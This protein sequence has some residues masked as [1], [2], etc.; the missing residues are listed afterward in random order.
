MSKHCLAYTLISLCLSIQCVGAAELADF[1]SDGCSQ[2][3]DGTFAQ[4][5]LWCD[6][7]ITHDIAYW[8]GGSR[9]QK[10]QADAALR[11]CVLQKTDNSLLADT[12]YYGVTLGGSPVF[13][14][15]YRWGYGWRYGRGFQSLNQYEQQQVT[16]KLQQYVVSM[17]YSSCDFD[18]PV[19]VFIE[20][21]VRSL[22]K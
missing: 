18:Y 20:Q 19:K 5:D 16:D 21:E 22:L 6:C 14:V 11:Q 12:M 2:F 8:Q 4:Q 10:K 15:W 1:S 7:C 9:Q 3:P 17:P 13:P